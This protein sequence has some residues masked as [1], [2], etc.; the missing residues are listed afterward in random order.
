MG[1]SGVQEYELYS[2]QDELKGEFTLDSTM[3]TEEGY[4]ELKVY[5]AMGMIVSNMKFWYK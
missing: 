3:A 2:K 1:A 5:G 4:Y